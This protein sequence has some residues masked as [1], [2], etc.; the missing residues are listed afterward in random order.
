MG[1]ILEHLGKHRTFE[2]ILDLLTKLRKH[3]NIQGTDAFYVFK[4]HV[5]QHRKLLDLFGQLLGTLV[6]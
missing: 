6:F 5:G 4:T 2:T 3:L 1:N